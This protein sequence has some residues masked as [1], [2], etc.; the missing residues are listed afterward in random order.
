MNLRRELR[1]RLGFHV[2]HGGYVWRK[3][4]FLLHVMA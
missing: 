3:V 4:C 1:M 2:V